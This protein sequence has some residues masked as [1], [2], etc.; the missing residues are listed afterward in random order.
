V[1]VD[2]LRGDRCWLRRDFVVLLRPSSFCVVFVMY[3]EA[4][5]RICSGV[6]FVLHLLFAASGRLLL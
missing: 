1:V 3:V 2:A 4:Y 6:E 5:L